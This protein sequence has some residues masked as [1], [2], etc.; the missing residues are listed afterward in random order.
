MNTSAV[1]TS[2]KGCLHRQRGRVI[3]T[4]KNKLDGEE[5]GV[6]GKTVHTPG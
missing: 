3:S 1:F 2:E 6:G 4:R 5:G